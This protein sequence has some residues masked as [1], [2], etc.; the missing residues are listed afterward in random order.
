MEQQSTYMVGCKLMHNKNSFEET[1]GRWRP[2]YGALLREQAG[3]IPDQVFTSIDGEEM[4]YRQMY[5]RSL[6]LAKGMVASGVGRGDHVA[7]LMPNCTDFTVVYF[8]VQ[9]LGGIVVPVNAR[10]K[11][12]ELGHVLAHSDAKMLFT[13]DRI[14]EHVNFVDLIW[15]TIPA[16]ADAPTGEE[17]NL[18]AAPQLKKIVLFGSSR[19]HPAVPVADLVAA[20]KN[21][22]DTA[23][24]ALLDAGSVD[25]IALMLYTS[26]TTSAPKGCQLTHRSLYHSWLKG[27]ADAV[28]LAEGEKVWAPLPCYHV[29]G[30]GPMTAV[31]AR[32]ATMLSSIHYEPSEALRVIREHQPEH[33]YPGFFTL[34][35]PVLREPDYEKSA[36]ASARSA[37]MVA[38]YE[39][40]L[41]IKKMMPEGIK[42]LQIFAMTEAS[43]YVTLTRPDASEEHRL[44]TSGTPLPEVEVRIAQPDTGEILSPGDEG[45]IQFRGP[46]AFRS[47]Y[48]ED[49]ATR[50]T[51]LDD[52]W[53]CTGDHGRMNADGTLYFLGRIKDMLK[54]GG[55]NVAA[56]EIE[57]YLSTHPAVKLSQVVSKPCEYYGE[58]AVAFIELLPGKSVTEAEIIEFCNGRLA[59]F[60]IPREVRFVT[61]WPMS[62]TKIQKFKL[63]EQLKTEIPG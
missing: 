15:Q 60:K 2:P 3:R 58:V 9:L 24:A 38:P 25:D 13:T 32:G 52:G 34:L 53:V 45:E 5:E 4:T 31:L 11:S 16:V 57:A 37:I 33:L 20:G 18:A 10:F 50:E 48:G 22:P 59:K 7:V 27:Y 19:R 30:I 51:I 46:V 54:I 43:G 28:V 17:L 23:P 61:E 62:A 8:A 14:D 47:Y 12:R 1:S 29:G 35:L 63:R 39:T 44:M 36:L 41:M 6:E 42:V 21:L 56:A 40:Q 49:S 55:E 26:G